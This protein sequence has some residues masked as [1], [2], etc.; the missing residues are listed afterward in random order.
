MADTVTADAGQTTDAGQT[1]TT[2]SVEGQAKPETTTTPA[3]K[4]KERMFV[5]N[6]KQMSESELAQRI[7]K[8]EGLEGRVA[9]AAK[10]EQAFNTFVA[11]SQDPAKLL[12]L[13]NNPK[14]LGYDD[15]KQEA[16]LK[17][18]L[19]SKKPGMVNAIKQW[20]Y[21]NEIEPGTMTP[22]QRQAREDKNA[23]T[24][25]EARLKEIEDAQK[26]EQ[27]KAESERIYKDYIGKIQKGLQ[28]NGLP[29][30]EDVVR[31][32]GNYARLQRRN[33]QPFDIEGAMKWTKEYLSKSNDDRVLKADD[34]Q[35][36]NM[37]SLEALKK[38]NAAYIKAITK[39]KDKET[40]PT[41][42]RRPAKD[43]TKKENA[44]FWKRVG[45]GQFS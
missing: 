10:L 34:T 30:T 41:G 37:F 23:R 27:S 32:A 43:T 20:L 21:E 39:G 26:A 6:G 9:N 22:E 13:L 28:D 14:A 24:A 25:A 11:N 35:I 12:D 8:A 29:M 4:T 18:M 38:I 40:A 5:I 7:Q 42:E 45:R 19:S 36:M 2:D 33:G 17:A 1:A 16:L 15:A 31:L 3:T 44:D